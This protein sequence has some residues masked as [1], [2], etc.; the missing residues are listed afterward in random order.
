M[1]QKKEEILLETLGTTWNKKKELR[2]SD[3]LSLSEHD[4]FP[5]T[6][7][8]DL[9]R[10]GSAEDIEEFVCLRMGVPYKSALGSRNFD[11]VFFVEVCDEVGGIRFGNL[12]END[13]DR[14]FGIHGE[15]FCSY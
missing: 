12:G 4:V 7:A 15:C 3:L 1:F 8:F 6:I 14:E 9:D 5:S 13:R 10:Q 11:V 2:G